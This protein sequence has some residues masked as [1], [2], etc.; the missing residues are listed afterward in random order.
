MPRIMWYFKSPLAE[1][2]SDNVEQ[3]RGVLAFRKDVKARG[4]AADYGDPTEFTLKVNQHLMRVVERLSAHRVAEAMPPEDADD[5]GASPAIPAAEA[6]SPDRP[7]SDPAEPDAEWIR[8]FVD[9]VD[10]RLRLEAKLTWLCKHL[11]GGPDTPT[12]ATI[13]SLRYDGFLTDEQA[14]VAAR[15]LTRTPESIAAEPPED[16][17]RLLEDDNKFVNGF[18]ASV[19]DGFVRQRILKAGWEVVDFPQDSRHRAD[20]FAER[21]GAPRIRVSPRFVFDGDSKILAL[22]IKRLSGDL[23]DEPDEVGRRMIVVPDR[24]A[25]ETDSNATPEIVRYEHLP[26]ALGG[27]GRG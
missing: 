2:T 15:I 6:V 11:L 26:A 18:R 14:R 20:F 9:V 23:T 24:G 10:L 8:P 21:D 22:T 17:E 27:S 16:L 25:L 3:I 12:F 1:A 5:D 13:G 19:F 7:D 4:L